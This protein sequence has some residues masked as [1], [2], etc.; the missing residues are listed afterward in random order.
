METTLFLTDTCSE[1]DNLSDEFPSFFKERER[2][3]TYALNPFAG[4]LFGSF[5]GT[6]HDIFVSEEF[7]D[8]RAHSASMDSQT[9]NLSLPIPYGSKIRLQPVAGKL[10]ITRAAKR[11]LPEASVSV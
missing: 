1:A 3:A 10:S 6:W 2:V 11:I 9:E 4:R 8:P 5:Y 7:L